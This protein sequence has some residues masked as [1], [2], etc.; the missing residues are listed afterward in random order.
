MYIKYNNLINQT[1]GDNDLDFDQDVSDDEVH[2]TKQGNLI[3]DNKATVSDK[4]KGLKDL[5]SDNTTQQKKPT[6]NKN[7]NTTGP[8]RNTGEPEKPVFKG[9]QN[10]STPFNEGFRANTEGNLTKPEFKSNRTTNWNEPKNEGTTNT[11]Y[12]TKKPEF[13][14]NS[15]KNNPDLTNQKFNPNTKQADLQKPEFKGTMTGVN[16][17][18]TKTTKE[19]YEIG[20]KGPIEEIEKRHFVNKNLKDSDNNFVGLNQNEDVIIIYNVNHLLIKFQLYFKNIKEKG[21]EEIEYSKPKVEGEEGEK[22]VFKHKKE[23]K[24]YNK[25]RENRD[26]KDNRERYTKD[27][28]ELNKAPEKELDEDGFEIVKSEKDRKPKQYQP[29][30]YNPNYHKNKQGGEFKRPFKPREEMTNDKLF[31]ASLNK[32]IVVHE[33]AGEDVNNENYEESN[34]NTNKENKGDNMD[35]NEYKASKKNSQQGEKKKDGKKNMHKWTTDDVVEGEKVEEVKPVV[36]TSVTFHPPVII[37]V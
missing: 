12:T 32:D 9:N 14:A 21:V 25:D 10:K 15:N 19:E 5:F 24:E 37:F 3:K 20:T 13:K 22:K 1:T 30:P 4:P 35:Y 8:K 27:R 28:R 11:N 29:R 33:E 6:H 36:A 16:S 7:K 23:Y 31:E 34:D 18:K 17:D 26:P 2:D